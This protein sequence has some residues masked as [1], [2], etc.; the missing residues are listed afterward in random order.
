MDAYSPRFSTSTV[1]MEAE[2]AAFDV[3]NLFYVLCI[4][5]PMYIKEDKRK[6]DTFQQLW[7][8]ADFS[9]H[10]LKIFLFFL[11]AGVSPICYGQC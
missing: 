11:Q 1:K 3:R 2:I 8:I 7:P 10:S 9:L 4:R 6:S 5:G